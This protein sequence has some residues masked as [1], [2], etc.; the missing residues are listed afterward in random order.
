FVSDFE[1]VAEMDNQFDLPYINRNITLNILDSIKKDVAITPVATVRAANKGDIF[2]VEGTVTSGTVSGNAFFDT[3]YL[4]DATGGINIFPINEGLIE[5]GQKVRVTGYLDEYLGDWELRVIKAEV[6]DKSI[7]KIE[8]TQMTTAQSMDYSKNGG[9]LVKVQGEVSKVVKKNDVVETI[10]VKDKIGREARVFIDGYIKYSDSTSQNLEDIAIEGNTISAV[11]L[12]SYDPE[13]VRLRVRDR[14]EIVLVSKGTSDSNDTSGSKDSTTPTDSGITTETKDEKANTKTKTTVTTTTDSQ[15]ITVVKTVKVVTD[16]DAGKI[17]GTDTQ[18]VTTG[19]DS[20]VTATITSD[21]TGKVTGATAVVE[22]NGVSVNTVGDKT[23]I[24]S[25]LLPDTLSQAAKLASKEVPLSVKVQLPSDEVSKIVA[26]KDTKKAE[27]LL[28]IPKNLQSDERVA[29]EGVVIPRNVMATAKLERKDMGVIIADENGKELYSWN[30]DGS[31]L[32]DSKNKVTAINAAL[33]IA[34]LKDVEKINGVVSKNMPKEQSGE[35][36]VLNFKHSGVLPDT[37][38]VR[39]YVGDKEGMKPGTAVFVYYFNEKSTKLDEGVKVKQTI[40]K[41]GY[42]SIDIKHCSDYVVLPAEP[43]AKLVATLFEQF[44]VAS[45][46]SINAGKTLNLAVTLPIEADN[47]TVT[48]ASSKKSVA[49]VSKS[50]KVIAKKA[51][52]TIITTKVKI[53]GVT[54]SFKTKITVK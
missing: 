39:A 45:R 28:A 15:G 6:I 32:K 9:M 22:V 27:I 29:F 42:L 38:S 40:D 53:N 52:T 1:V 25:N 24:V 14:S 54:K 4:Q 20:K 18:I 46:K 11:G 19:K 17:L 16:L 30:F 13:G 33:D 34:L 44:T 36:L 21:A 7:N 51:G 3:I 50:G 48:Y 2:T 5:V 26:G 10:I 23:R 49:S 35:G 41:D 31:S 37:A 8:P 12:V 47:A 43:D